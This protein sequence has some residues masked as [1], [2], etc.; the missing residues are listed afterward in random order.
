[1]PE[2]ERIA[3]R[4]WLD[5]LGDSAACQ[6]IEAGIATAVE[7]GDLEAV[8]SLLIL[9]CR[10]DPHRAERVRQQMLDATKGRI[11]ITLEGLR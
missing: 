3:T 1:M 10:Y 7:E 4:D 5:S 6:V 9:M 11:T 8:P 2:S